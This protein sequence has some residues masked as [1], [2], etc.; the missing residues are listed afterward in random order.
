MSSVNCYNLKLKMKKQIV[1]N[2]MLCY[3]MITCLKFIKILYKNYGLE[4]IK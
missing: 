2:Y 4:Y 1:K 3:N